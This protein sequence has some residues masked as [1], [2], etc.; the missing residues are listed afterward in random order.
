MTDERRIIFLDIDGT[1]SWDGAA[2]CEAD[3]AALRRARSAGHTV[4]INT[5]RSYGVL[6]QT[7]M[8]VDY[9]DGYLCGCGTTLILKDKVVFDSA[10]DREL[11]RDVSAFFLN[12]PGR[13]C[14]FEA[15]HNAYLIQCDTHFNPWPSAPL[16]HRADDF[17]T[18][19]ADAHITKLTVY[20]NIT[21]AEYDLYH[22][23]LVPVVQS[24]GQWYEAILPGNG[25]GMG[26]R[27][28]CKALGIPVE[29]S[30]A[31]GDSDNDLDM[32]AAAGVA[33]AMEEASASAMAAA[34]YRT[35][36][37]GHGGV[38]RAVETLVFGEGTLDL[39]RNR[40]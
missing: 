25:K 21:P 38:A 2:P 27:R 20:G 7:F 14:L 30:I 39:I 15:W 36:R 4:L 29:N 23:R 28:A 22:G 35:G 1:L 11:L 26:I 32:F 34:R 31:V 13:C 9:L 17:D 12:Q 33:V 19:Y 8:G 3:I 24:S 10:L 5:G 16:V 40:A 6:P 37:C 18:V